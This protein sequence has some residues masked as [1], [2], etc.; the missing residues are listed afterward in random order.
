MYI[1]PMLLADCKD[2]FESDE[3]IAE[4]KIDGIRNIISN[5]NQV[6]VYTRHRNDITYRF[7][8]V[9]AAAA[10]AI[11]QGTKLDGELAVCDIDT[12]KPNFAAMM[13]RFSSNP[14]G[15][16]TPGLTFVAFDILAY[17][18]KDTRMLPLMQRKA[19]LEEA[20][21]ENEIIKRIRYTEHNFIPLFELCKQQQLEGMVIKRKDSRY[22]AGQRPK[23]W[24]RV[25]VFQRDE[26]VVT[27]FS[28]KDSTWSIGMQKNEKI[29]NVGLLKYGLTDSIRKQ[30]YPL[31]RKTVIKE[32]KDF[33]YV[34]PLIH[35]GVRFRHWTRDGKMRLPVL[36][37]VIS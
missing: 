5:E 36:E 4:L 15:K 13:S 3:H 9:V 18:G 7:P 2:P 26:V 33:A 6:R 10:A 12:G 31:L 27:G 30:I 14:T 23:D 16:M 24:Q 1:E 25:V 35:L 28:K 22:R 21:Q 34:E 29:T 20:I 11:D 37:R 19:L 32:T 17:K 8:E